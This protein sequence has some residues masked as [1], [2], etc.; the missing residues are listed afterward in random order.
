MNPLDRVR[1]TLVLAIL[2]VIPAG[3]AWLNGDMRTADFAWR[4]LAALVLA[5]LGTALI[6][7]LLDTYRR[8]GEL[9]EAPAVVPQRRHG[10]DTDRDGTRTP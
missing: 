7:R 9:H 3:R 4:Y 1:V 2:L 10:D 8:A 5:W 6:A